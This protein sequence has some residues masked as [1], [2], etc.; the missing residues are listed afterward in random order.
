MRI[1]GWKA[2][3][4]TFALLC[5]LCGDQN[6]VG[7]TFL[8]SSEVDAAYAYCRKEVVYVRFFYAFIHE[9]EAKQSDNVGMVSSL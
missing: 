3:E 6:M 9:C 7:R 4:E 5:K 8:N 1:D 2:R